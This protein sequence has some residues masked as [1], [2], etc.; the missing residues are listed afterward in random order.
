MAPPAPQPGTDQRSM[1]SFHDD[2]GTLE[3]R[4]RHEVIRVQ[5]WGADSAR[6]RAAQHRLPAG[7]VAAL[8]DAPPPG[9]ASRIEIAETRATLATGRLRVEVT[10]DTAEAYPEPLI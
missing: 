9:S 2:N 7:S 1:V 3:V 10:F 4:H 6:V 8:D 5:A